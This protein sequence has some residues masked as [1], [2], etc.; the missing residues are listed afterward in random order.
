MLR[1]LSAIRVTLMSA[2]RLPSIG[3]AFVM[4]LAGCRSGQRA[5]FDGPGDD[6]GDGAAAPES[7]GDEPLPSFGDDATFNVGDA[8]AP[9]GS[10]KEGHYTGT[11]EGTYKSYLTFV[12]IPITFTANID[13]LLDESVQGGEIPTY[14]IANGTLSGLATLPDN[15]A[16]GLSS[17]LRCD[18]VGTLDCD[19]KKLV[20]GGLRNCTYCFLGAIAGGGTFYD[21]G[22]CTG[23]QGSFEGP[24]EADYDGA[25][26]SFVNGTWTAIE[27]VPFQDSGT[28]PPE[29]G[30]SGD[31]GVAFGPGNYG[32]SGTWGATFVP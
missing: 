20:G 30:T 16:P 18:I 19:Q 21:G 10:C 14:N 5:A 6:G 2:W 26:F 1:P 15:V 25:S 28:V 3:L 31:S 32:G 24:L 11:L 7:G 23:L 9:A 17:Q 12:G 29:A 13:L 22:P 27:N 8:S 4:L